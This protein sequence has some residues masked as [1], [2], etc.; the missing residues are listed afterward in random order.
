[1]ICI[2]IDKYDDN[3]NK[4]YIIHVFNK[5]IKHFF[6]SINAYVFWGQQLEGVAM[7]SISSLN[8]DS[9]VFPDLKL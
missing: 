6:A 8:F 9:R 3:I 1:M 2:K 5:K 4:N 7:G